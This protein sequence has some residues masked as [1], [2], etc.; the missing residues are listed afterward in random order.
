MEEGK[1]NC[2]AKTIRR[3]PTT[4]DEV[5]FFLSK[6]VIPGNITIRE[7]RGDLCEGETLL[8]IQVRWDLVI[9]RHGE[10]FSNFALFLTIHPH[11]MSTKPPLMG[12]EDHSLNA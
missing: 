7:V 4:I 2:E 12:K 6:G 9:S 3:T 11:S 10:K 1:L 5:E 8:W